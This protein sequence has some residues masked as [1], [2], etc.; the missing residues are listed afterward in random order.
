MTAAEYLEAARAT[1]IPEG[2]SGL[3]YV[4]R[5]SIKNPTLAPGPN[6][7]VRLIDPGTYTCLLRY[8]DATLHKGGELVMH[9]VKQELVKHLIFMMRARGRVLITGLGLGCVLRGVLLNPAVESV[10]VVE[11]SPDVIKLVWP[12]IAHAGRATLV[13]ADATE[14]TKHVKGGEFDCAWHDL[15][16]DEE[17]ENSRCLQ[18]LHMG[19]IC[20]LADKVSMQGAWEFPRYF[21]KTCSFAGVI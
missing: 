13:T 4:K 7:T 15:W 17:P 20:D 12:H 19:M 18:V 1:M 6:H 14:Y 10:V 21:R 11:N 16:V 2:E 9:D 5:W 8:T 3:W